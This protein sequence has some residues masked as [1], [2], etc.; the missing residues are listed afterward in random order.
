MTLW[1]HHARLS[2]APIRLPGTHSNA[3]PIPAPEQGPDNALPSRERSVRC[4]L[5]M[6]VVRRQLKGRQVMAF[7]EKLPPCLIS[8]GVRLPVSSGWES[9]LPD[10]EPP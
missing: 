4:C 8:I 10:R 6:L 7:F 2:I 5:L 3:P 9:A 1:L